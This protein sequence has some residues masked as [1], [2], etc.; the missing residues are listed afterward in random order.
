[1]ICFFSEVFLVLTFFTCSFFSLSEIKAKSQRSLK[2]AALL[3]CTPS[4]WFLCFS[5]FFFCLL[6]RIA[7]V[8]LLLLFKLLLTSL[9]NIQNR[10]NH[11]ILL[12]M[13][14][15]LYDKGL[16]T[17]TNIPLLMNHV[18]IVGRGRIFQLFIWKFQ[19]YRSAFSYLGVAS[20]G[21]KA[22]RKVH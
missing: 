6:W 8:F 21:S 4:E 3:V 9:H 20:R 1:M 13:K 11:F 5:V 14:R 15:F 22:C 18:R 7:A 19:K 2:A 17:V 12:K 10:M 16:S